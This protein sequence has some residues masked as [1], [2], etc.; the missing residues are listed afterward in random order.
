ME[1]SFRSME[2]ERSGLPSLVLVP[3][4]VHHLWETDEDHEEGVH[5]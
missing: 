5:F 3:E 1:V 2:L 4:R